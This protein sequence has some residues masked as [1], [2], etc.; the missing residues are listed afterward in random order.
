[1]VSI[2]W[3]WIYHNEATLRITNPIGIGARA[4]HHARV[5]RGKSMHIFEQRHRVI[6]LPIQV[7]HELAVRAGQR[8]FAIRRLVLH[9]T[10]FLARQPA[11]PRAAGP[12]GFIIDS[13]SIKHSLHIRKWQ[14]PLQGANGGE[15]DEK[16]ARLMALEGF[17]G[18]H[19][20][21]LK[22][23]RLIGHRGLALGHASNQEGH[24]KPF[25]QIAVGDPVGQHKHLV[26]CQLHAQG[27]ALNGKRLAS[28]K[29]GNVLCI[30]HVVV[31]AVGQQNAQ[32]FKA[33]ANGGDGLREVQV[34][35][36]GPAQ[37]MRMGCRIEG[38]NATTWEDISTRRE[39]GRQRAPCHEHFN[40]LRAVAQQQDRGSRARDGGFSLGVQKLL[41]SDHALIIR[42]C[43]N[44]APN[45]G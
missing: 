4:R 45:R 22:L 16:V 13:T 6:R 31:S 41:R 15:D 35:L 2:C 26:G 23:L 40:A 38:V 43:S 27:C 21:R 12:K 5:G 36:R 8:Q 14:E 1:M 32:F 44:N 18:L 42:L 10:F 34:A 9:I 39:T 11:R 7:V 20:H 37:C 19:P 25:G 28:V 24:I 17:G 3:T 33:F 30:G 29:L